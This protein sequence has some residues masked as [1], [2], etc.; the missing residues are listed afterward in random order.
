MDGRFSFDRFCN[1]T[2]TTA[3][4]KMGGPR[5]PRLA[6]CVAAAALFAT[7]CAA[8][9]DGTAGPSRSPQA[10]KFWDQGLQPNEAFK[11]DAE[12]RVGAVLIGPKADIASAVEV[13]LEV[14]YMDDIVTSACG[15]RAGKGVYE[16]RFGQRRE[17]RGPDLGIRQFVGAFASVTARDA[18]AQSRTHLG[19]GEYVDRDGEH[20]SLR[21]VDLPKPPGIDESVMFCE[22][23]NRVNYVC[24]ALLARDDI[25]TRLSVQAKTEPRARQVMGTVVELAAQRLAAP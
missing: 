23:L 16:S 19:C 1:P 6:I 18:V 13:P 7:S 14:V 11:P 5:A 22:V 10:S 4:V 17:W 12:D 3:V 25:A 8:S 24:I 20:E 15:N 2:D 9:S 21:V